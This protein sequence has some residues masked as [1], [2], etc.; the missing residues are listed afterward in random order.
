MT[1]E[2]KAKESAFTQ[3][4]FNHRTQATTKYDRCEDVF[5]GSVGLVGLHG[6]E[7]WCT[8]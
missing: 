6:K 7:R 3:G 2:I 1:G 4:S 5:N 8:R